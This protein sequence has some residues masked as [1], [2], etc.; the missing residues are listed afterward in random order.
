[1]GQLAAFLATVGVDSVYDV[2]TILAN[3]CYQA[4]RLVAALWTLGLLALVAAASVAAGST[5]DD[6]TIPDSGSQHA[7]DLLE[8]HGL[9][10]DQSG[11]FRIVFADQDGL[12]GAAGLD[13]VDTVLDQVGGLLPDAQ[14]TGP[15]TAAGASQVSR[16][17]TVAYAQ[18]QVPTGSDGTIPDDRLASIQALPNEVTPQA[19]GLQVAFAGSMFQT[20]E[21][22]G[23]GTGVGILIAAVLLFLGF[24]SLLAMGLP[25]LVA[26]FGAGCG[27]AAVMLVANVIGM[28]SAAVPLAAMLAVGVGIDYSL[29]VVTRYREGLA[30]GLDP[31]EAVAGAQRTAGRSVF[32]AGATVVIAILG[33]LTMG[34]PLIN[35][36]AIGAALAIAITMAAA[37]TLLPALLGFTGRKIDRFGLRHRTKVTTDGRLA[38][39]WS[40]S[41][42]RHPWPYAVGS[43]IILAVLTIPTFSMRLGFNDAST[44]PPDNTA[45]QAYDMLADGFGPGINGPLFT[46]VTQPQGQLAATTLGELR[47]R[48]SDTGNV[49]SVSPPI[50]SADGQIGMLVVTPA[51]GPSDAATAEL[52]RTLDRDVIPGTLH[53]TAPDA[54]GYLTGSTAAIVDFSAYTAARIPAFLAVIMALA[55][56]L[57]TVVFRSPVVAAKAVLVNL[58]S[59]GASFGVVVAAVQW[60]WASGLF[61]LDQPI[62]VIA[63]VPMMMVAVVFGLSM[64]YEVF[65]L[66]RIKEHHDDGQ[67]NAEA[68]ASGLAH[69]ARVITVAAAI[70]I[71][72]FAGFILGGA[73]D[74]AVF[75][76][77]LAVAV[78]IDAS[79]VR[80]VL[81][82]AAME[83]LG[84]Y[85]WW[86][87][88]RWRRRL[89]ARPH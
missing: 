41:V 63:W 72:V 77:G 30:A 26:G 76:F 22:G 73:I 31:G 33:L 49:A 1:M 66:S 12:R 14:I 87:P 48:I 20:T 44:L 50:R 23:P 83:L 40:H 28:S 6:Y 55:L 86:L 43:L 85:N 64:D 56:C 58:L 17:G 89:S 29:F 3:R 19:P 65:L 15:F 84:E 9:H 61:G 7:L 82:P 18:V 2:L 35:G 57:L 51:T 46:V 52:A 11:S 68:V 71:C 59:I 69:T 75:G 24:G 45:R 42:Q 67:S 79:L 88:R 25:L 60:G 21:G 74:L 32:F 39:R 16:D 80:L 34:M 70:M 37:L 53:E 54:H 10:D 62:P 81:V 47:D 78:L 27:V 38:R 13:D 36:V 4:R 5:S 8:E